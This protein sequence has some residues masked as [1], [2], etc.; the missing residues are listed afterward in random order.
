MPLVSTLDLNGIRKT[1]GNIDPCFEFFRSLGTAIQYEEGRHLFAENEEAE[2]VYLVQSGLVRLSIA[3]N[4]EKTLILR[5]AQQGEVLGLGA[6]LGGYT[7]LY[8]AEVIKPMLARVIDRRELISFLKTVP[9]AAK[10]AAWSLILEKADAMQA[11]LRA[12]K[13]ARAECS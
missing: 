7:H 13:F 5:M 3:L 9:N 1:N 10:A 6:I 4:Q 12:L 11:L 2:C 8:S